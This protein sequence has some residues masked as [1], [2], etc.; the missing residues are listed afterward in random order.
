MS[1]GD[2]SDPH[3]TGTVTST[4]FDARATSYG[5]IHGGGT[6]RYGLTTAALSTALFN[7]GYICGTC[8]EIMCANDPQWCLPRSIKITDTILS[9]PDYSKTINTLCNPPQKHFELSLQMFLKIA[10]GKAGVVP[11]KCRRIPCAKIGGVKFEIR[12]DPNEQLILAYNI[13]GVGD[14]KATRKQDRMDNNDEEMGTKLG[15]RG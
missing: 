13:G 5:D 1:N 7:D 10:K 15:A 12:D 3:S 14:I 2:E 4:W 6:Q 9:S 11:V 8:Y